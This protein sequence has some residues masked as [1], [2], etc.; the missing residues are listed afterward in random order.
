MSE[1]TP[2]LEQVFP[3]RVPLKVIGRAE[4]MDP[5][6]MA[7]LIERHLGP[8]TEEDRQHYTNQKGAY[9]SFT[10][11][12]VLPNEL[13]ELPLRTALQALPGVVMQL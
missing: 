10:F 1:E 7:A 5:A 11:W 8:Q 6:A 2:R 3:Q 13:A 12:V 9:T 4:E